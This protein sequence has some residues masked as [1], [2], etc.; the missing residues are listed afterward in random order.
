VPIHV[1]V[2]AQVDVDAI[3][4]SCGSHPVPCQTLLLSGQGD[5]AHVCTPRSGAQTQFTPARADLQDPAPG[6]HV[7]GVQQAIDLASLCAWQVGGGGGQR[8]EQRARVRHR[9][10]KELREQLVG[11]VVV[12]GDVASRLRQAV[13]LRLRRPHYGKRSESL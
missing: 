6:S 3:R 2:V 7:R 12:F 10:V 11:Q 13:V 4:Q 9:L 5:R 1:A 8:V